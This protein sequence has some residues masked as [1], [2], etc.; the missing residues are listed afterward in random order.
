MQVKLLYLYNTFFQRIS[1]SEL[2]PCE[3]NC[4]G[5]CLGLHVGVG[6]RSRYCENHEVMR[7]GI[8]GLIVY[9]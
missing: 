6:S 7:G 5:E 3:V 2:K 9:S 4:G 1:E 8:V